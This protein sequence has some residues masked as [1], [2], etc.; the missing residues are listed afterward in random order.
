MERFVAVTPPV[1]QPGDPALLE[2]LQT[3]GYAAVE[4]LTPAEAEAAHYGVWAWLETFP[5]VRRDDPR[6]HMDPAVWPPEVH[7][8]FK[9]G[10]VGHAPIMWQLRQ[11]PKV[12]RTFAQLWKVEPIDLL[13]SFDGLGMYPKVADKLPTAYWAHRDQSPRNNQLTSVQ[14]VLY[15]VG[16]LEPTGGGLVV[17]PGSHL[18]DFGAEFPDQTMADNWL[19]FPKDHARITPAGGRVVRAPAGTLVLWDSRTVH[20]NTM[21]TRPAVHPRVVAYLCMTPRAGAT[22]QT[23][24]RRRKAFEGYRTSSHSPHKN[25]RMNSEGKMF[26]SKYTMNTKGIIDALVRQGPPASTPLARRL[27]GY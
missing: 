4:V 10:G 14:G 1:F 3:H 6:T 2:H 5:G 17:W 21:P 15:I 7:G 18:L 9:M 12:L 8:I 16:N 13:T 20:Q 22:T 25:F 23:L 26:R 19:K 11:H 27:V 24:R